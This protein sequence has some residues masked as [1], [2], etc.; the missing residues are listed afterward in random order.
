MVVKN[1]SKI[2]NIFGFKAENL[3]CYCSSLLIAEDEAWNRLKGSE[4]RIGPYFIAQ[5]MAYFTERRAMHD[6]KFGEIA[7][8]S[9]TEQIELAKVKDAKIARVLGSLI[10]SS[11]KLLFYKKGFS[12]I[13]KIYHKN[14]S[15]YIKSIAKNE[16]TYL[17]VRGVYP[18]IHAKDRLVFLGTESKFEIIIN[19][20]S[21]FLDWIGYRAKVK[22]IEGY[23]V[24][25]DINLSDNTAKVNR[26]N[27]TSEHHLSS[28]FIPAE[29]S[30][31]R[32]RGV[33]DSLLEFTQFRDTSI[34][35]E[36]EF[37]DRVYE[38]LG[39]KDTLYIPTD[40]SEKTLTMTRIYF[41]E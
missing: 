20:S 11:F 24:L 15:V 39:I 12:N 38:Q 27:M 8:L 33:Y 2:R 23:V 3:T 21:K 17:A 7:N 19:P 22:N 25:S 26:D 4:L 41:Y 28:L 18:K 29:S 35:S 5:G 13:G 40:L 37:L 16:A 6:E 34:A 1:G 14:D 32:Q 30:I 9:T 31:L 10:Y 36:Y